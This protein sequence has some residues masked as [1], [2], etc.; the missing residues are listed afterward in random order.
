M[1]GCRLGLTYTFVPPLSGLLPT[2]SGVPGNGLPPGSANR[3]DGSPV[4]SFHL[5]M[6]K[7]RLVAHVVLD[8]LLNPCREVARS[9]DQEMVEAFAAQGADEAFGDRSPAALEPGCG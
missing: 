5:H 8:V 3:C 9:S 2:L 4:E 6:V 1:S 7:W